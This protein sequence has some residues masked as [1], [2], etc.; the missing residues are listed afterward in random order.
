MTR[1]RNHV[2]VWLL[3]VAVACQSTGGGCS[4]CS[5]GRY[6]DPVPPGGAVQSAVVRARALVCGAR[7]NRRLMTIVAGLSLVPTLSG[8]I[9]S[10]RAD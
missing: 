3:L 6:P 4:G 10:T 7:D 2:A 1:L 5:G 8:C 9:F